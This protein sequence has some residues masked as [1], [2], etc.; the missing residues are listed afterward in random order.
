[1]TRRELMILSGNL[2][3]A[4]KPDSGWVKST[5]NPMLSLGSAADFYSQNIMSP[6]IVKDGGQYYL[7]Y[8]GGPL[9]PRNGGTLIKYQLGLALSADGETWKKTGKPLLPLGD[10]DNFHVTPTLLRNPDG[11]LRKEG[12]KWHL[13]YCGNREDDVEY[14]TS[15]DGLQW[16]KNNRSPI[17][18]GAY[19]P[20]LVQAGK[21]IRM[22][23]IRKPEV[24]GKK[25]P[26]EVHLATGPD[27]FSLKAHPAN[28][29]L[30]ISQ[31]WETGALFYP[32]VIQEGET[33]ILFYASYWNKKGQPGSSGYT[34][35][36]MATSAD[37][38]KWTKHEANPILTPIPGSPYESVYNSSQS[39][40]RDGDH[41][42]MYYATRIDKIH[43]YYAICMARK[44]GRI[45]S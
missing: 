4:A 36:A 13:V 30:K 43:K 11:G 42:K 38:I 20:N 7:F 24:A 8:A 21:E 35:I 12:G 10:R 16:A 32:Y 9:G 40:I 31:P 45:L 3:F 1:M 27:L 23:Y 22:Y 28:P 5:R 34:A 29:M 33:W 26:W 14:A 37:G 17:Y 2:A 6:S 44:T 19:A 25:I 15:S 41:Y 39:V 18:R